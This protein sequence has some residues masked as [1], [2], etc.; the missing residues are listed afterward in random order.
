L[1]KADQLVP[2][3]RSKRSLKR[4]R[5][6]YFFEA[7]SESLTQAAFMLTRRTDY[8]S[9]LQIIIQICESVSTENI[10]IYDSNYKVE[11]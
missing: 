10:E 5:N 9:L 8:Y 11:D 7:M 6:R 1:R 4:V 3:I 2:A